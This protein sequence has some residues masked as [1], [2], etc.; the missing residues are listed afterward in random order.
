MKV[1][2]LVEGRMV[3]SLDDTGMKVDINH[4]FVSCS[5][6]EKNAGE[7]VVV[8]FS[9]TFSHTFDAYARTKDS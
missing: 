7:V 8:K 5:V 2:S 4:V 9:P 6:T 1:P 3:A